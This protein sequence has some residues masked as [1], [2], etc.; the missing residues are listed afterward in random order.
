MSQLARGLRRFD[1]VL[2][3]PELSATETAAALSPDAVPCPPLR[4]VDYGRWD[5][6]TVA[7]I[8][9]QFP[10]DLQRWMADP[11]SA[12]HGG[13]PLDA[14]QVRA[15]AWLESL[16]AKGGSTLAVTHA[17]ILKLLFLQVVGAPLISVWR[18]DVE[19]LGMLTL[20]SD[21]RRWALRSFGPQR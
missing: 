16:H 9:E 17:L 10:E 7:D 11:S 21:G 6:R 12:P 13:E 8:T 20:S 18:I 14:V 15:A 5:G 3:A 2:H 19:P 4:D 1:T